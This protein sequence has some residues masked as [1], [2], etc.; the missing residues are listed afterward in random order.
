MFIAKEGFPFIISLSGIALG[1][2]FILPAIAFIFLVLALFCAFFF[3]NPKRCCP[4]EAGTIYS[5]ADGKITDIS[6]VKKNNQDYTRITIF[7]SVFNCHINRIPYTG[8]VIKTTHHL[9]AFLAAYRQGI[10]DKNER[11]ESEIKTDLGTLYVV[12]ITG[13]IAR[14]IKNKL[15]TGNKVKTGEIFGLIM[16][17]SR[18]DLYLP[19]TCDILVKKGDRIKAGLSV[20]AK[21]PL[22]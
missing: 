13:A 11:C 22:S 2:Y 15:K 10:E 20:V 21:A 18:T 4:Q 7:L 6:S 9:G 1:L 12:Q 17:G 3:R 14:R 19:K 5:P 8:E 16:F